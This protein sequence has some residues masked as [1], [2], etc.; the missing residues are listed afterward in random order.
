MTDLGAVRASIPGSEYPG[1][2]GG[3]AE[4]NPL[5]K[6]GDIA[7]LVEWGAPPKSS[8]SWTTLSRRPITQN[9]LSLKADA[10]THSTTNY[11]GGPA[12]TARWCRR[13]E[14]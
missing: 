4:N 1:A 10:V 3:D 2:L 7:A 13:A 8:W 12:P 11:L 6:D 14:R 5:M 9:P